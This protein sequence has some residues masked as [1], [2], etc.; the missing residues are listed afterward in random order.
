MEAG[1]LRPAW[2]RRPSRW[3]AGRENGQETPVL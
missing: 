1:V 3:P 2:D